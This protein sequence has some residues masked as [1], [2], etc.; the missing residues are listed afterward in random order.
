MF[1]PMNAQSEIARRQAFVS[2]G[3]QDAQLLSRFLSNL[4][5]RFRDRLRRAASERLVSHGRARS[6][7]SHYVQS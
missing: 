3:I 4:V 1:N 2:S 5:R 7:Q 6:V